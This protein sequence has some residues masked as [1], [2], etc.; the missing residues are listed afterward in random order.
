[1]YN[2]D[3]AEYFS[4]LGEVGILSGDKGLKAYQPQQAV[5]VPRRRQTNYKR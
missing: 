2:T 5:Y 1:M 4:K 3:V